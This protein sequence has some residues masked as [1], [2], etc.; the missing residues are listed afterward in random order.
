MNKCEMKAVYS[1]IPKVFLYLTSGHPTLHT[2]ALLKRRRRQHFLLEG[3]YDKA[4]GMLT[5]RTNLEYFGN[6]I[7]A[8][9]HTYIHTCTDS[10]A[11]GHTRSTATGIS[12]PCSHVSLPQ[13]ICAECTT[14]GKE[15]VMLTAKQDTVK[16]DFSV[17]AH[18]PLDS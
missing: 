14:T 7:Q 3:E 18:A 16:R 10:R 12:I 2:L 13:C 4:N 15:Y 8:S 6:T 11:H 5:V 17:T 9:V 1:P